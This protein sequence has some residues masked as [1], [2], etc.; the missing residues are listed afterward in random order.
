MRSLF[1]AVFLSVPIT[2]VSCIDIM[3]DIKEECNKYGH[4]VSAK[5]PRN[6]SGVGKVSLSEP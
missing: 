5:I 2:Q 6:G 3:E 4:V 1:V